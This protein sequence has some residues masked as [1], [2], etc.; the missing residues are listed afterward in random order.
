MA[1]RTSGGPGPGRRG[2]TLIELLVA[3][4]LIVVVMSIGSQAFV[5]GLE[6][7]RSLKG[8]GDLNERLRADA[9]AL[10]A[11]VRD[12]NL[13]AAG[14][15]ADGLRGG[16]VDPAEAAALRTRYEA[17]AAAAADLEARLRVVER[18]TVNPAAR[19]LLRRALESLDGVRVA[20]AT[21]AGLLELLEPPD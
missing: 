1:T 12:T 17:I 3:M 6:T 5:S 19:R 13:A 11:D 14:F 15:I 16:S 9:H 8:I 18:A 4:A 2:F 20:A 7:F 10:R 21:T